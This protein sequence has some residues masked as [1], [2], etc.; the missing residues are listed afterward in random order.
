MFRHSMLQLL[1]LNGRTVSNGS[2]LNLKEVT[3]QTAV[4]CTVDV[5]GEKL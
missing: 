2:F 5:N 1:E 4:N 3:E